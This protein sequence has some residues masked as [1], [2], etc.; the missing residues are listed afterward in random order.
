VVVVRKIINIYMHKKKEFDVFY[1][2]T[3]AALAKEVVRD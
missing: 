2:Q 3:N 1:V